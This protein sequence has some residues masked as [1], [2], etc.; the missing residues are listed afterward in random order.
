MT[1]THH[2]IYALT[3]AYIA[4]VAGYRYAEVSHDEQAASIVRASFEAEA[5]RY[6][7]ERWQAIEAV[8]GR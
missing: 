8:F 4:T 6:K 2:I 3:L 1:T 5:E 7:A